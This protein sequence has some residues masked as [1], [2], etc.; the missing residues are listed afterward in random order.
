MIPK[1]A[2]SKADLR[3]VARY[4]LGWPL[5]LAAAALGLALAGDPARRLLRYERGAV[6]D[7]EWWRLVSGHVVHLGWSH[8][9]LNLAG[10][11]LVWALV[12]LEFGALA[13]L[14]VLAGAVAAMAAGFLV[15]AP[16]L[17]WYV[18][19]SGALHGL[20]VA[21]ALALAVRER[22]AAGSRRREGRIML[23]LVTLKLAWEQLVGP[24][25]L[26]ASAAGGPVI[27]DAHLYGALGG[28]GA[29]GLVLM[30]N[31]SRR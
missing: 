7:G 13:W 23:A 15:L 1:P 18:G 10:L 24:M 12:G 21:G 22:G 3:P 31:R 17:A 9:L 8:T 29:A 16:E 19:L 25:P 2:R 26:S 30:R 11:G 20:F 28:L 14:A 27:V 5:G 4:G 6:L